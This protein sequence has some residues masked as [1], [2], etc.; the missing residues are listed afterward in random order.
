MTDD[1]L[2]QI[3]ESWFEL[4]D[5]SEIDDEIIAATDEITMIACKRFELKK[6]SR[7]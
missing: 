3:P 4:L 2:K 5:Q 6:P 7:L 1:V